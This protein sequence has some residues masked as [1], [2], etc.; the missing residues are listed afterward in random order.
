MQ[1]PR[2]LAGAGGP[3]LCLDAG[4]TYPTQ[5][6]R[7][8]DGDILVLITDGITEAENS[9]QAQYG[10]ARTLQCLA[11]EPSGSAAAVCHKLHADVKNFTA[12]A[13]PSD[14]LTLLAV[15]Y[16]KPRSGTH[17]SA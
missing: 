8:D 3:P 7:L 4:F 17:A 2:E 9:A 1:A 6:W 12:G 5:R 15:G 10:L 11:K 16:R 13:P 14:D